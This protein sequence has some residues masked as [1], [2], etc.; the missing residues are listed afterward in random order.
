MSHL[1]RGLL[2]LACSA[3]LPPAWGEE[4]P[5]P[6][7]A[8]APV[9]G[10][11][12]GGAVRF[13]YSFED[14]VP[15]NRERVG[16]L[17]F[18]TFRIN[19]DGVIGDVILSA[20]LRYYQ[21]MQVIHHAWVGYDLSPAWRGHLGVVRVPFGHQ[22]FNSNSYFFSTLYYAGLEDDYDLGGL[23]HGKLGAF[24]VQLGL[25]K[26]D[27]QGGIDGYVSDRTERY[28]YDL[29]GIRGTGEGTFDAPAQPIAESNTLALRAAWSGSAGRA[30]ISA[31]ASALYGDLVDAD[32]SVG[33]QRAAALHAGATMGRW[34]LALQS[35]RYDHRTDVGAD[36]LVVGAYAFY[37]SIP[38]AATVHTAHL[39]YAMPVRWGPVTSLTFYNDHSQ[40]TAKRGVGGRTWMNTLGMSVVAGGL[41][42]YFD[43]VT[44]RNQPFIGGSLGDDAGATRTR[45]NI[46]VGYYF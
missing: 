16:D 33:S 17:D 10:I 42:T 18:D 7:L 26:N 40:M 31:G 35:T 9:E 37:D 29:L 11:K 25:F 1:F 36:R 6:E 46:N 4:P 19:L 2:A 27:E 20:E 39:A 22:P 21:Y 3:L 12:V 45:F 32:D 13:Q 41:F 38:A 44:A 30:K 14:Y 43:L 24:D 8:D 34:A 15:A 28:S 23:L 5:N